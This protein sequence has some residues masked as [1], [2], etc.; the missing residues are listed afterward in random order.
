MQ[1]NTPPVSAAHEAVDLKNLPAVTEINTLSQA[2]GQITAERAAFQKALAA[3]PGVP[4]GASAPRAPIVSTQ[5]PRSNDWVPP[6]DR[7]PTVTRAQFDAMTHE[8]RTAFFRAGGR[9]QIEEAK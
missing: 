6:T 3:R 8:D 7:R 9:I 1:T 2:R 5:S 4:S